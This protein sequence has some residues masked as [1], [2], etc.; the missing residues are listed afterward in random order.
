MRTEM[1]DDLFALYK[2]MLRIRKIEE[3]IASRYADGKI[4]CPVHLSIGQEAI[5]V[6]VCNQLKIDD[7]VFSNHRAHAHY[8]AKGGNLISFI[9]EIYGLSGGC[10]RG[11]GGSMHIIDL[12]A[13]FHGAVPIV[14]ATVP[15]AVGAAWAAKLRRS[16]QVVVAFFGD[17]AVEEGVVHES[18]NFSVLHNLPI[19][20]VC[21]NNFYACYTHL[22]DRQ[23]P[24][25]KICDLAKAHG[26]ETH[27]LDGNDVFT[28]NKTAE[29]VVK[30]LR[31]GGK[32][33]F[34]ECF[35]YRWL[36]HC[37][38]NFDDHL[39]YRANGELDEWKLNCPIIRAENFL[40]DNGLPLI[41]CSE[42]ERQIDEEI[43]RAFSAAL[44]S[45]PP[46]PRDLFGYLYA[47]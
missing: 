43:E 32:P 6:G 2:S 33:V 45:P 36:E 7:V 28:I 19:L 22:R 17:G 1:K 38:P 46:E 5:A 8:L 24:G 23:Q 37:G 47:R 35:T 16:N 18:I 25:R 21:E 30:D 15:L 31:N 13:G 14:G 42:A 29:A 20:F 3:K 26:C 40:T 4:R 27:E 12:E 11:V 39:K 34:I 44:K 41:Q 9:S 10:S